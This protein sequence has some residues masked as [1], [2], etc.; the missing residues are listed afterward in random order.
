MCS[1]SASY[2]Q[3]ARIKE[4]VQRTF[5]LVGFRRGFARY[6]TYKISVG[7]LRDCLV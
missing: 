5:H 1:L 4:R 7:E 2:R 6:E 3:R